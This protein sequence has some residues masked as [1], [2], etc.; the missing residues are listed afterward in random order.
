[1]KFSKGKHQI[2]YLGRNNSM[3]RYTAGA[4]WLA[5]RKGFGSVGGQQA[6]HVQTA[7]WAALGGAFPAG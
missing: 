1:M 7:S 5:S 3:H 6:N 4:G 2:L